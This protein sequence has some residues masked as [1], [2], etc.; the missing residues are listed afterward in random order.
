[1]IGGNKYY[2]GIP[3][4]NGDFEAVF[5]ELSQDFRVE[6]VSILTSSL[7]TVLTIQSDTNITYRAL[8]EALVF[9]EAI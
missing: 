6:L 5:S 8:D 7:Y 1:M 9:E 4:E 2:P 3:E